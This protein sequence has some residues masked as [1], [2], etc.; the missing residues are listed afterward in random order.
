MGSKEGQGILEGH[1]SHA[2]LAIAG[3]NEE[4]ALRLLDR[5]LDQSVEV[6]FLEIN[7]FAFD[8]AHQITEKK[9]DFP[10]LSVAIQLKEKSL[11]LSEHIKALLNTKSSPQSLTSEHPNLAEEFQEGI[12]DVKNYPLYLRSPRNINELKRLIS[13][14][15]YQDVQVILIAP[16]RSQRA[17]KYI[18]ETGAKKLEL[19]YQNLAKQFD[20]LL[21][22]TDAFWPNENFSDSAHMNAKGRER[23]MEELSNWWKKYQ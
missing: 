6:V 12:L 14:A 18:G 22:Q 10:L 2:R 8:F 21:F 13:K 17:A 9:L 20:L 15:K 3:I 16:P 7:P 5:V 11:F 1:R 19:H 4:Q 23:F